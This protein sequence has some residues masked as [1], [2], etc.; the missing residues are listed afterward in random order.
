MLSF[1]A[2]GTPHDARS[3]QVCSA[4]MGSSSFSRKGTRKLLSPRHG[5]Q[6]QWC[7]QMVA[8]TR[9]NHRERR[10]CGCT[11]SEE[12]LPSQLQRVVQLATTETVQS[13]KRKSKT[14]AAA[15][16][17]SRAERADAMWRGLSTGTA[18]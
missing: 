18:G 13:P 7:K 1:C 6:W 8:G 11:E 17:L 9:G 2:C 10:A 3:V 12:S 15:S 16:R 5:R 4:L 14:F